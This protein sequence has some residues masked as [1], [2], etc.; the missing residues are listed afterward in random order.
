MA[1]RLQRICRSP[2]SVSF[3]SGRRNKELLTFLVLHPS[4][5]RWRLGGLLD[6]GCRLCACACTECF[7]V[8]CMRGGL[9]SWLGCAEGGNE[10]K[11][12]SEKCIETV[13]PDF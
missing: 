13:A 4:Q 12:G 1:V 5:L 10:A 9:N 3:E 11:I 7:G 8:G 2:S 6:T